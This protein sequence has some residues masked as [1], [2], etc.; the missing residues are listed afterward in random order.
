VAAAESDPLVRRAVEMQGYGEC[1]DSFFA[2]GLFAL[3]ERSGFFPPALV[4]VFEPVIQ[5]EA[6]HIA[7]FINWS[8]ANRPW[9]RRPA[10]RLHCMRALMLQAWK[11]L[12]TARGAASKGKF[13]RKS[14]SSFDVDTDPKTFFLLCLSENERRMAMFDPRL[15][16]PRAMPAMIGLV[17]RIIPAGKSKTG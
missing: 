15:K 13:T 9:R 7:F 2:F 5:E 4:R 10:F 14:A 11:R 1:F 3:A 12:K 8:R 6:R 16:R 17:A